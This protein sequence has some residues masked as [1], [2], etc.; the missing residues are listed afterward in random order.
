MFKIFK[1]LQRKFFLSIFISIILIN[2]TS[3]PFAYCMQENIND[4]DKDIPS[5][6]KLGLSENFND[7][8]I[9]EAIKEKPPSWLE[10]FIEKW[11]EKVSDFNNTPLPISKIPKIPKL[12]PIKIP[13][14]D[15]EI[16][17]YWGDIFKF[18]FWGSD[19][20]LDKH[21]F[22]ELQQFYTDYIFEKIDQKGQ[23]LISSLEQ[24]NLKT[25]QEKKESADNKEKV[26]DNDN[27]NEEEFCNFVKKE[28]SLSYSEI[29]KNP[30][31]KK[32]ALYFILSE[33][34]RILKRVFLGE[35][36]IT[37]FSDIIKKIADSSIKKYF[38]QEPIPL[39]DFVKTFNFFSGLCTTPLYSTSSY[40]SYFALLFAQI[41][42]KNAT[43]D[44]KALL[45][46]FYLKF[47]ASY[48]TLLLK[49]VS[50]LGISLWLLDRQVYKNSWA[51]FVTKN[52][53]KFTTLIKEYEISK[54]K[55]SKTDQDSRNRFYKAEQN[56]KNFIKDGHK[57]SFITW[58]GKK[59]AYFNGTKNLV[60]IAVNLPIYITLAIKGYNV[61]KTLSPILA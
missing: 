53:E 16:G 59:N 8:E 22:N 46:N 30:F 5:D 33:S 4:I 38:T 60:D 23:S 15:V 13:G 20:F 41:Q 51:N 21:L 40:L 3:I 58:L 25:K 18:A 31:F 48:F 52:K 9:E 54:N 12:F 35:R 11:D 17:V 2:L 32:L 37:S 7:P 56:L 55:F 28:C 6:K 43:K 1:N 57:I 14:S 29:T 39:F 24:F 10:N 26:S 34:S 61:A 49:E 45:W 50:V 27:N 42:C 36:D 47:A 19:L 44:K